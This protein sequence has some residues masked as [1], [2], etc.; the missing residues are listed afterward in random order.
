M[1]TSVHARS[2]GGARQ[3][4]RGGGA[5]CP[6][7]SQGGDRSPSERALRGAIGQLRPNSAPCRGCAPAA[8]CLAAPAGVAGKCGRSP[9]FRFLRLVSTTS[10][11]THTH[12]SRFCFSVVCPPIHC[13]SVA[14]GAGVFRK[15]GQSLV[16]REVP[17]RQ[18]LA[19]FVEWH[20]WLAR[21]V[22]LRHTCSR[23][24]LRPFFCDRA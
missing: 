16:I 7:R 13:W 4:L 1:R 3:S 8:W 5:P 14:V 10:P 15:T 19:R 17:R 11:L 2:L 6:R 22:H 23:C 9:A 21:L 12:T 18:R 24:F 20:V